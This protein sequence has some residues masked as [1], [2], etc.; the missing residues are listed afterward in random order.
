M[1][2]D[3]PEIK[4]PQ[5]SPQLS[6]GQGTQTP[7]MPLA[8]PRPGSNPRWKRTSLSYSKGAKA[9]AGHWQLQFVVNV[10]PP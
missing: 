5:A 1:G 9:G 7:S 4:R 10:L 3:L 6:E 2:A 8:L